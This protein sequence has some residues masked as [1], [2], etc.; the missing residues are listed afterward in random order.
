MPVPPVSSYVVDMYVLLFPIPHLISIEA[1]LT[2]S[3]SA[4][5]LVCII[6]DPGLSADYPLLYS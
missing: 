2:F 4:A 3:F 5:P 6:V 1:R